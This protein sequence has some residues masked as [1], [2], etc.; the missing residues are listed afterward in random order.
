MRFTTD[1]PARLASSSSKTP[2]TA[3]PAAMDGKNDG[4]GLFDPLRPG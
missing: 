2:V 1:L 4:C 3:V